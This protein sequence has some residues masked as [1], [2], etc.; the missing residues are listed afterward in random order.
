MSSGRK[1]HTAV[2]ASYEPMGA[3]WLVTVEGG[4]DASAVGV[5]VD[6]ATAMGRSHQLT[7][8]RTH[9]LT[10]HTQAH[11]SLSFP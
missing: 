2:M 3:L 1:W 11:I 6:L 4:G 5:G 7:H 9:S 10:A 8:T